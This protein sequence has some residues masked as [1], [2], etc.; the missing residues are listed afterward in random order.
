MLFCLIHRFLATGISYNAIH[1]SYRI[2]VSTAAEIVK[3]TCRAIW[4]HLQPLHMPQPT[5]QSF[6]MVARGYW[7]LWDFPN[8][9]GSID[10]KHIR[11]Q[12]PPQSGSMYFNYKK[13]FSVV[14]QAVA[15]A[16]YKFV[17]I[18]VG[19]FGKQ[20]D[21]GTFRASTLHDLMRTGQLGIPPDAPLPGS[22]ITAP[23]VL[24][25]DEAY[26]LLPNLLRPF[27]RR[28]CDEKGEYFNE[29]LSKARKCIE[30]A[31]GGINAKWRILWKPIETDVT[32]AE[33]ITKAICVLHNTIIDREG[34]AEL[35]REVEYFQQHI[36]PTRARRSNPVNVSSGRVVREKFS[37][38][39]W[40]NK[41]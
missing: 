23:F 30:C 5:E 24:V 18:E 7:Q 35:L 10:G 6:L 17:T 1:F 37:D 32:T 12:C 21:G 36:R 19:A 16:N 28:N 40:N 27:S 29:R 3:E 31:F 11:I 2:G 13:F 14:L 20:S 39:V 15:D 25:G 41:I 8:C 38:F 22:N 33:L 9:L 34:T 4:N 26:P